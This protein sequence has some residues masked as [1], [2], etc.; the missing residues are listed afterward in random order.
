MFGITE[1]S[2]VPRCM[3]RLEYLASEGVELCSVVGLLNSSQGLANAFCNGL[4]V[5]GLRFC[6][7]QVEE[8]YLISP[9]L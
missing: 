1:A 6:S 9:E 5:W 7:L 4:G 3:G 8:P 2:L